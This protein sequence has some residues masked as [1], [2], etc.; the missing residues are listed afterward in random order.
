MWGH[1]IVH[2]EI[3]EKGS[4]VCRY[5]TGIQYSID[6]TG[7]LTFMRNS[8]IVGNYF[9]FLMCSGETL[10]EE[11]NIFL[12]AILGPYSWNLSYISLSYPTEGNYLRVIVI[13]C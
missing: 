12:F 4:L 10:S 3:Q 7:E 13:N 8:K 6:G 5:D 1:L 9:S 2:Q 11:V